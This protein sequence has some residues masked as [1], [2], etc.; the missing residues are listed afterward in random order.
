MYA[1]VKRP[2]SYSRQVNSNVISLSLTLNFVPENLHHLQIFAVKVL[3]YTHTHILLDA[4]CKNI[5]EWWSSS[6]FTCGTIV[7]STL[8]KLVKNKVIKNINDIIMLVVWL[9]MVNGNPRFI[10]LSALYLQINKKEKLG[11]LLT[12]FIY[13]WRLLQFIIFLSFESTIMYVS[14]YVCI[15]DER[16]RCSKIRQWND[17]SIFCIMPP[18]LGQEFLIDSTFNVFLC[19]LFQSL[20]GDYCLMGH[21][22][23]KDNDCKISRFCLPP[24]Y[25]VPIH[26]AIPLRNLY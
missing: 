14:V 8:K 11:Y 3:L 2:R 19:W 26:T 18:L 22:K 1:F 7:H 10:F 20:N 21:E 16:L 4:S 6:N 24:K 13:I 17:P 12:F 9:L 23:E 25:I 5:V 15:Y